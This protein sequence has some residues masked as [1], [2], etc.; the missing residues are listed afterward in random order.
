[1][2]PLY[3]V[4]CT[5]MLFGTA[6]V[7][8]ENRQS[9]VSLVQDVQATLSLLQYFSVCRSSGRCAFLASDDITKLSPYNLLYLLNLYLI[10]GS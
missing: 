2:I 5:S 9:C 8:L 1:M 3:A 10:P 7:Q 4:C 6:V